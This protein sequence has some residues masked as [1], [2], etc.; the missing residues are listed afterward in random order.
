MR[1]LAVVLV[2][3][4]CAI[5]AVEVRAATK[6]TSRL[7]V[8]DTVLSTG[9]FHA[10][11]EVW[12]IPAN[13]PWAYRMI[14]AVNLRGSATFVRN[15]SIRDGRFPIGVALSG[16][17]DLG[18][19][20]RVWVTGHEKGALVLIESSDATNKWT[21]EFTIEDRFVVRR[22]VWFTEFPVSGGEE[23]VYHPEDD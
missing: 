4:G 9:H 19:P 1:R 14:G 15:V 10:E 18:D 7:L 6:P 3:I 2:F 11:V 5:N 23:T 17:S 8:A 12:A 20:S 22:R 16:Y 21:A 13:F